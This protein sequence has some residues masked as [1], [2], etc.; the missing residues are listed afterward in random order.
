MIASNHGHLKHH[1]PHPIQGATAYCQTGIMANGQQTEPGDIA[2]NQMALGTRIE[3]KH[4]VFGRRF[5]TVTD[6]IGF[7]SLMD[8]YT[9]SCEEA[10][11]FGRRNISFRIL[12]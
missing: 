11:Q 8:F 10:D 5:F 3:T 7:G 9:P 4:S 2:N 12:P 1:Y 6:R